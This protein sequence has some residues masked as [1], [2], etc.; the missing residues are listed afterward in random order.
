MKVSIRQVLV[1]MASRWPLKSLQA[2][3][4]RRG[5]G[6]SQMC[7]HV[8]SFIAKSFTIASELILPT[9]LVR[10]INTSVPFRA[11]YYYPLWGSIFYQ[12][13][14]SIFKV[15]SG[16]FWSNTHCVIVSLCH[17][18][19]AGSSFPREGGAEVGC[20]RGMWSCI[21]IS[22][23]GYSNVRTLSGPQRAG[24]QPRGQDHL[25]THWWHH[26]ESR[27]FLGLCLCISR[28]G[29]RIIPIYSWLPFPLSQ[30]C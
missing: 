24:Q 27:F 25:L 4:A 6:D 1:A 26:W 30:S 14:Y 15:S 19:K 18:W 17:L 13:D 29:I 3:T 2:E 22:I 16:S 8:C 23:Q 10:Q 20:I 12:P 7:Y 9:D 28:M 5:H 11:Q 21:L